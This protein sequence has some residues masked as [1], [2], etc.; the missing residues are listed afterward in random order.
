[1][2]GNLF[3]FLFL[4]FFDDKNNNHCI[5]KYL[6]CVMFVETR[7]YEFVAISLNMFP[8]LQYY[9]YGSNVLIPEFPHIFC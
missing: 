2:V 8:I 6:L 7:H 1:M 9:I 4:Y 3:L 5:G